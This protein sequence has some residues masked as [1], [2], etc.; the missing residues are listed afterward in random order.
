MKNLYFG[1]PAVSAFF[2]VLLFPQESFA[3]AGS[4]L[5]LW[6]ETLVPTLLPVMILSH[7]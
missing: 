2:F 3:A 7:L 6:Y 1:I 4:G 5:L